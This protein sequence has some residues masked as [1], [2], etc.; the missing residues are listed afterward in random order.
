M[1]HDSHVRRYETYNYVSKY[2]YV[3]DLKLRFYT[4]Y[5]MGLFTG[6]SLVGIF[7]MVSKYF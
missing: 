2:P 7:W 3:S 4:G 6:G 1:K 5:I